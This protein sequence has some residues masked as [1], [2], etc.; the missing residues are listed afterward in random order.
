MIVAEAAAT[1]VGFIVFKTQHP[2]GYIDNIVVAK[3]EQRKGIGRALV[4]YVEEITKSR[5]CFVMKT[6]TSENKQGVLGYAS[7]HIA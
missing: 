7:G 6:D 1:L 2:Y 5:G 3:K 4:S